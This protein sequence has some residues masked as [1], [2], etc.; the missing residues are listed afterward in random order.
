MPFSGSSGGR[1]LAAEELRRDCPT[2]AAEAR[3]V[4]TVGDERTPKALTRPEGAG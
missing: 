2:A 4:K 1:Q 3:I